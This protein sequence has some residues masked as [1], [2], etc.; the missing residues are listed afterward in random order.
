VCLTLVD[1]GYFPEPVYRYGRLHPS[2]VRITK[3]ARDDLR[4]RP[5]VAH[6]IDVSIGGRVMKRGVQLWLINTTFHKDFLWGKFH[7]EAGHDPGF[8]WPE[9]VPDRYALEATGE[10]RLATATGAVYQKLRANHGFDT[11]V[12]TVVAARMRGVDRMV[13]ARPP[14]PRPPMGPPPAGAPD[15]DRYE[16]PPVQPP[17]GWNIAFRAGGGAGP[18]RR[19]TW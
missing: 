18:P 6:T 9:D 3:G 19:D 2:T 8:Y 10:K 4:G 12:L 16:R 1:S 5:Y 14:S 17:G 7:V 13:T 15:A 11:C